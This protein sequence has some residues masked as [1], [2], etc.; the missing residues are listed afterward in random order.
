[1]YRLAGRK[2]LS[3]KIRGNLVEPVEVET[4]L[5]QIPRVQAA[6]V[7]GRPD[8]NGRERLVAYVVPERGPDLRTAAIRRELRERIPTYMIPEAVVYLTE[9]PRTDRGKLDRA[10]L[11]APPSRTAQTLTPPRTAWEKRVAELW[12]VVLGV[13]ELG[14][15]D[16]FFDLGGDSLAAEEM[17]TRLEE[18]HGVPVSSRLLLDAPSVAEFAARLDRPAAP[19]GKSLV[20]LRR[21]GS[22]PPLFFAAAA[23]QTAL[24]FLPVA[25]RLSAEQPVYALQMRLDD[26]RQVRAWSVRQIARAN[27]RAM[28]REV[29]HGPYLLAGH[30]FGG[31]VAFEM[32]QQLRAAGEQ[33]AL[34]VP[35]DSFAPHPN[36]MPPIQRK[37]PLHLLRAVANVAATSAGKRP[38]AGVKIGYTRQGRVLAM[39]YRGRPYAGR[40]LVVTAADDGIP[41]ARR[42]PWARFLSGRWSAVDVPGT[43]NGI[44]REPHVAKLAAVLDAEI[45]AVVGT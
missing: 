26:G 22:R 34:L 8:E 4:A 15:E 23:G 27:V 13:D 14:R 7:L 45:E 33:V 31:T 21:T 6:V 35:L 30:S 43:H 11:P 41:A 5:L 36:A 16:D 10:A 39:M 37:N 18:T 3:L 38:E 9:L 28:R 44:L 40:T 29:P 1:M 42:R 17:V 12:S 19:T 24:H 32:A 2:D 25:R 20:A